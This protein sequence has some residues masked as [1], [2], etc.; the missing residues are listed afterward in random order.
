MN[1]FMSDD[2]IQNIRNLTKDKYA[3]NPLFTDRRLDF[4]EK[5]PDF[6]V[7]NEFSRDR[8]R[9][10]FSKAFRRLEHKAQVYSHEKGDHYRNRLTHTIEVTQ[11]ARSIAR[12]LGLNEDLT[13]A[14]SLGHDIGHTPF[15]HQGED[16]LDSIMRGKNDLG[17]VLEYK[18]SYGG[19]KH[20]F[21]GL[22][23]IDVLERKYDNEK[24][25]NLTWQVM[26]GILKHT[27]IKKNG[28][29]WDINRFI[30][31]KK[32]GEWFMSY[33]NPITLEGQIVA[34]A[35][36]IAQRQHDLDDGLRDTDLKLDADRIIEYI[37]ETIKNIIAKTE[38]KL[39]RFMDLDERYYPK[40]N[41]YVENSTPADILKDYKKIESISELIPEK[42][43]IDYDLWDKIVLTRFIVDYVVSDNVE[44][45]LL[46][47]LK[48]KIKSRKES[49][50]NQDESYFK[51]VDDHYLWNSLI[52]D[53]IDYFIKDVTLNSLQELKKMNSCY[54]DRYKNKNY[55]LKLKLVNRTRISCKKS[56]SRVDTGKRIYWNRRKYFY[57]K[58]IR[59]SDSGSEFDAK[60]EKY[61]NYQILNSY[62]VNRFDGKAIF[63]VKQLF[64][65]YYR[66]PKQ[67][68]KETL[69]KLSQRLNENML[70]YETNLILNEKPLNEINFRTGDPKDINILIRLLKLEMDKKELEEIFEATYSNKIRLDET[71]LE[72]ITG[73]IESLNLDCKKC[74]ENFEKKVTGAIFEKTNIL[75][76]KDIMN[77]DKEKRPKM[78][79]IKCLLEHHY[80]YLSLICDHI[81]GMTD[82][83]AE[84]EYKKL[85]LV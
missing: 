57:S 27:K 48:G 14:I 84:N 41:K 32:Q 75:N 63:I 37:E 54:L 8:D 73:D 26:D 78:M 42:G 44:V 61:I 80:V 40:F 34:L 15:G 3:Q 35:D 77:E 81:A 79:F 9:I 1:S 12:N 62:T 21:N 22:K 83:Y 52:R 85:Y 11:I 50:N 17:G 66:N 16:V 47:E 6:V 19:F 69:D 74:D 25:L 38:K 56:D 46:K 18:I 10:I 59:F 4:D 64:K 5:N 71:F 23:T 39:S 36:E 24:G 67:M 20:N 31:C 53:I 82:N 65:A 55:P 13:E 30:Q 43:P 70:G 29:T 76:K 51:K 72:D 2:D 28:K 68:P 33:D 60:L 7:R 45:N 49:L 58:I